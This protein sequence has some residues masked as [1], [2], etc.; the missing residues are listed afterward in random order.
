MENSADKSKVPAGEAFQTELLALIPAL[1]RQ[2]LAL[3]C[4][5]ALAEDLMQDALEAA[6]KMN[7]SYAQGTNLGAWVFTIMRHIHRNQLRKHRRRRRLETS[8]NSIRS[9]APSPEDQE[10]GLVLQDALK[11]V[12][13]MHPAAMETFSLVVIDGMSYRDAAIK[14]AV[15]VGTV[16][17][18]VARVRRIILEAFQETKDRASA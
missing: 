6:L 7:S 9:A 1:R 18:R 10:T 8:A 11:Q 5:P 3:S 2:A 13:A 12:G 15:P 17:S 4:N 16:R 14:T